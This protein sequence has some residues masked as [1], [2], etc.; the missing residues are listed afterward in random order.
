MR[1]LFSLLDS[2][3]SSLEILRCVRDDTTRMLNAWFSQAPSAS[4]AYCDR[5]NEFVK[6]I[7]GDLNHALPTT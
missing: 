4:K 5:S 6:N 3:A 7:F 2:V 1:D